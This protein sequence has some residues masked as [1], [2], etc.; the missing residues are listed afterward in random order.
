MATNAFIPKVWSETLYQELEKELVAVRNCNREFE[1]DIKKVGDMVSICGLG[2]IDVFDYVK[3]SDMGDPQVLDTTNTTLRINK[4]KAFNFLIDDIDAAQQTPAVMQH[5][6]HRAAVALAEAADREVFNL[7]NNITAGNVMVKDV[8]ETNIFDFLI[9]VRTRLMQN[10]VGA[11]DEIV[12]E[13][14]PEIAAVILKAKLDMEPAE[15]LEKG[16]IGR[17]LGF[18]VYVSNHVQKEE[19]EGVE[20][21]KCYARTRRAI[22]FAQQVQEMEAYRPELRFADAIKGMILFGTKII[23]AN[24][25]LMLDLTIASEP[26]ASATA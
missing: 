6:M 12:L 22:A 18:R 8:N 20:Y 3:N 17:V 21:H 23:Y 19:I 11:S 13:V 14:S 16:Y 24:E 4:C 2:D 26:A 10:N 7:C 25:F 9:N 15:V 5:A 1:G